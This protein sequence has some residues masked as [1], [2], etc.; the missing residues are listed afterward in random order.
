MN[1]SSIHIKKAAKARKKRGV[2]GVVATYL[3]EL[4]S[5]ARRAAA[6]PE[7]APQPVKAA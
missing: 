5:E 4:K 3:Y 2:R 7:V 6:T 1:E